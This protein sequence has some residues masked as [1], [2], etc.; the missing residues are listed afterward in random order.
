MDDH[1]LWLK[2]YWRSIVSVSTLQELFFDVVSQSEHEQERFPI[3][4]SCELC[5]G[6]GQGFT[7][8]RDTAW[9]EYDFFTFKRFVNQ[10]FLFHHGW[11]GNKEMEQESYHMT[12][13]YDVTTAAPESVILSSTFGAAVNLSFS[14]RTPSIF[15]WPLLL[16]A[17]WCGQES[18][19]TINRGNENS[20]NL[21]L[22]VR[23]HGYNHPVPWGGW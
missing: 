13:G 15:S 20:R 22:R 4:C 16:T 5:S 6:L 1:S 18:G 3:L 19:T 8:E 23:F 2:I 11:D 17:M 14:F 21:W 10:W 9:K 12:C 7:L